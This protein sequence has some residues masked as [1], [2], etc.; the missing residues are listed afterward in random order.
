MSET[1]R[2]RGGVRRAW[3]V[4]FW[5]C[6]VAMVAMVASIAPHLGGSTELVRMRNAL[7]LDPQ[8]AVHDWTP[9]QPPEGFRTDREADRFFTEVLSANALVVPGDDWATVR[10][11]A[12]HLLARGERSGGAI[13][14][15]LHD[16]YRR[17]V[18]RGEGYCGDFTDVVTAIATAAGIPSRSWAFSFD[19]FGGHGHIFNEIW[20]RGSGRWK[21][22]DVFNNLV[23]L[24]ENGEPL[25][26][27]GLREALD[28]GRRVSFAAIE[29]AARPGFRRESVALDYYRRGLPEWYLWWGSNVFEY[30]ANPAVR[31]AAPFGRSLE[32]LAGIA[33]GVHPRIRILAVPANEAQRASIEQLGAQLR[34]LA[35]AFPAAFVGALGCA[36]AGFGRPRAARSGEAAEDAARRRPAS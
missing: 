3:R 20:D 30:D 5:S 23:A 21:M 1:R 33:A 27:I 12:S 10:R 22:I 13:Q 11:I 8:P 18:A 29:P 19:G 36:I 9:R 2:G 7:L 35:V 28:G 25:S 6:V 4:G 26:S 31:A 34:L 17:I 15:N 16:T 14:A 32:Q 24:D